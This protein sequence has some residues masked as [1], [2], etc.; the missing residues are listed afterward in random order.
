MA[1]IPFDKGIYRS[2][3]AAADGQLD[4]CVNLMPEN[5][6]MRNA[7]RMRATGYSIDGEARVLAIHRVQNGR[8]IIYAVHSDGYTLTVNLNARTWTI[9]AELGSDEQITVEVSGTY[10]VPGRGG[11]REITYTARTVITDGT[12]TGDLSGI[13]LTE[14][15][16]FDDVAIVEADTNVAVTLNFPAGSGGPRKI[17]GRINVNGTTTY[18]R[19][20]YKDETGQQ[21]AIRT[22]SSDIADV[23]VLGNTL[24]VT[25]DRVYYALWKDSEYVWL[26]CEFPSVD[27]QFR[28]KGEYVTKYHNDLVEVEKDENSKGRVYDKVVYTGQVSTHGQDQEYQF[29]NFTPENG[30]WYKLIVHVM[31]GSK[32]YHQRIALT[33]SAEQTAE[34]AWNDTNN[35]VDLGA[36][37]KTD[38]RFW[39][40]YF[41]PT[42][43]WTKLIL[44]CTFERAFN[45]TVLESETETEDIH[46]K[47]IDGDYGETGC[48]AI[49]GVANDFIQREFRENNHFIYPFLVRYAA[50]LY[51]GSYVNLSSPCLL[52]PNNNL[53]PVIYSTSD[54]DDEADPKPELY[55][56]AVCADIQYKIL[57]C[58]SLDNWKDIITDIVVAVTPPAYSYNQGK[59]FSPSDIPVK[60]IQYGSKD[61][62]G[63][64]IEQMPLLEKTGSSFCVL[65]DDNIN[66]NGYAGQWD[67]DYLR[68]TGITRISHGLQFLLPKFDD[69]HV[70][71]ELCERGD[72]HIIKYIKAEDVA[73]SND[74]ETLEL[75]DGTLTGL[76]SRETIDESAGTRT[77][78]YGNALKV[79]NQR[80]VMGDVTE[81]LNNGAMPSCLNG[82]TNKY[83]NGESQ[84]GTITYDS[85]TLYA[86]VSEYGEQGE[87]YTLVRL[88]RGTDQ[89]GD[90]FFWLYYPSA[91][92]TRMQVFGN[93]GSVQIPDWR[94]AEVELDKHKALDGAYWFGG[95]DSLTWEAWTGSDTP[96]EIYQSDTSYDIRFGGKVIQSKAANPFVFPT[97][98]QSF[99][100]RGDIIALATATQALSEGQF[101]QF[102]IYA[103]ATDGIWSLNFDT[104]GKLASSQPASLECANNVNGICE[105]EQTVVF[106]TDRGIRM[107]GG[108][109][110]RELAPQMHG[111]VRKS[112]YVVDS[113]Y[114]YVEQIDNGWDGLLIQENRT[115]VEILKTCRISYDYP[116]GLLH[117]YPGRTGNLSQDINW[118]FVLNLATEQV[119]MVRQ[120]MPLDIVRD[121]TTDLVTI[122]ET[123]EIEE[124]TTTIICDYQDTRDFSTVRKGFLLTRPTALDNALALKTVDDLR[125]IKYLNSDSQSARVVVLVSDDRVTWWRLTSLRHHSFRWFRFA[126]LTNMNDAGRLTGLDVETTT[127]RAHRIR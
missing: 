12:L 119:T 113:L 4:V 34:A 58:Q 120:T 47:Q 118:H 116:N 1:L 74:F 3:S 83:I 37:T 11:W 97:A 96:D 17:R 61:G 53:A 31:D 66:P 121:L 109:S 103:F 94:V 72:F 84:G 30:K 76:E 63:D 27:I 42:S 71:E 123:D 44:F 102:P 64:W 2:P 70:K 89:L 100:T 35:T 10:K 107:I 25:A 122:T 9:S 85:I 36:T 88:E 92:A 68:Y 48:T 8:N 87:D 65:D 49:M 111:L 6:E 99:V 101:G 56:G 24:V 15:A 38:H 5:G 112:N 23:K 114:Q 22:L 115:W 16:T 75:D 28:L 39:E 52:V 124:E 80:L 18:N 98:L 82:I 43:S 73:V 46:F 77:S 78:Y 90:N 79:Y 14:S 91:N 86:A 26:G 29:V 40:I 105:T 125:V 104:T 45:I 7:P 19:L 20:C 21:H 69:A 50:R 117:I 57:Q 81:R 59:E 106:T 93:F 127:R 51:D 54:W 55:V 110:L 126:I 62:S 95:F 13:P 41:H 108:A 60:I 67:I 33:K 32:S